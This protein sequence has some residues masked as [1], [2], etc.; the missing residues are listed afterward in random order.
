MAIF[1]FFNI[2]CPVAIFI[3]LLTRFVLDIK[4]HEKNVGK[5]NIVKQNSYNDEEEFDF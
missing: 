1:Y 5:R 2:L 3:A 4:E